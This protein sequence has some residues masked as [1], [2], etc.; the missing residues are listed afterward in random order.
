MIFRNGIEAFIAPMGC[1]G[2]I[3]LGGGFPSDRKHSGHFSKGGVPVRHSGREVVSVEETGGPPYFGGSGLRLLVPSLST[4]LVDG[5]GDEPWHVAEAFV[6]KG[7]RPNI[8][9]KDGWLPGL[10]VFERLSAALAMRPLDKGIKV[11]SKNAS[12]NMLLNLVV[13]SEKFGEALAGGLLAKGASVNAVNDNG[14][15]PLHLAVRM[16]PGGLDLV[17]ALLDAGAEPRRREGRGWTPLD[18]LGVEVPEDCAEAREMARLLVAK[19]ADPAAIVI[20]PKGGVDRF[21]A[22][23]LAKEMPGEN[24]FNA[25]LKAL[26]LSI[27]NQGESSEGAGSKT[28]SK[29]SRSPAEVRVEVL[30][31]TAFAA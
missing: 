26:R 28:R 3:R 13:G 9:N 14:D 2:P 17:R 27:A 10:A 24:G 15:A 25:F 21:S 20:P 5:Q 23:R 29:T 12:G 8:P 4:P 6:G 7:V 19:G 1:L 16:L 31:R 18:L 30:G 22:G 11:D